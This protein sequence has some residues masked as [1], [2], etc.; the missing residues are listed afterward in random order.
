ML[1]IPRRNGGVSAWIL[2]V[3]LGN[4]SEKEGDEGDGMVG[5]SFLVECF[6]LFRMRNG[7][8]LCE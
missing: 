8:N 4:T 1:G 6:H 2:A 3:D 7:D 5:L